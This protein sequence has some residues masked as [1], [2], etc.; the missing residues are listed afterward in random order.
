MILLF[1]RTFPLFFPGFM[2]YFPFIMHWLMKLS[3]CPRNIPLNDETKAGIQE[4]DD[5]LAGKIPDTLRSFNSL[6][7]MIADL[8]S[9]D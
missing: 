2:L 4:V 6:E 9:D 5:M 3:P 7:E 8:D 1:E